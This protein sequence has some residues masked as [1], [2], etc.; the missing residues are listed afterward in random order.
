MVLMLRLQNDLTMN[1]HVRPFP[2]RA[3]GV[4][5]VVEQLMLIFC[6]EHFACIVSSVLDLWFLEFVL[7]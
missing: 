3:T 4:I 6:T 1:R 5:A 7:G 2:S